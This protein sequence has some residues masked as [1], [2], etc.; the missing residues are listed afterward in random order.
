M[1]LASL[2][3]IPY[4]KGGLHLKTSR[5]KG[6]RLQGVR[7]CWNKKLI[8]LMTLP[9]ILH[10]VV[11]GILPSSLTAL[12]SL[13]DITRTG[14][15]WNFIG[16][17]NYRQLFA[18]QNTRDTWAAIWRTI[19]FAVIVTVVKNVIA[20]V[21]AVL[22]NSK[23]LHGRTFYRAM[24]FMPSILGVTVCCY[25]WVL[26]LG[27]DGPIYTLLNSLGISSGLLGSK[28]AAFPIIIVIQI[29][30]SIGYAMVIDIAGLQGIPAELYEA[31][32]IDGASPLQQFFKITLP[33]LWSTL[34]VN[35]LLTTIGS[36]SLVQP[37]LLTTGGANNTE[38]LAMRIYSSA[39]GVGKSDSVIANSTM[40]YASAQAMV[41]F[42][43]VLV[44]ALFVY[45]FTK[46][47]EDKYE[48]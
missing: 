21:L 12:F 43:I 48:N 45:F 15:E 26:M 27:M 1:E 38:T 5:Q 47:Q 9:A 34:S 11:F 35:I 46:K 33:L 13:T 36:L 41:L 20:L 4:Y 23:T 17:T 16:L 14:T 24:T 8:I 19:A 42:A 6:A 44:F 2:C 32:A 25:A 10:Y 39:F 28:T 30:M 3:R 40:G 29:W 18:L 37:I 22:F 7:P 31:A